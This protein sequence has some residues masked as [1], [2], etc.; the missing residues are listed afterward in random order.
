[1]DSST[2]HSGKRQSVRMNRNA[3]RNRCT[4]T[5]ARAARDKGATI[6]AAWQSNRQKAWMLEKTGIKFV[7]AIEKAW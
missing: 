7:R 2:A 1:M 6:S 3:R 4:D 5:G